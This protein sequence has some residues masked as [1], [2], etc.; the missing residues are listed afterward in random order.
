MSTADFFERRCWKNFD[1]PN[2]AT[3]DAVA[4]LRERG[5]TFFR[6]TTKPLVSEIIAEG[7]RVQPKDQGD[8]PL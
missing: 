6:I 8:P 4:S 7:W 5:A 3:E 2:A 1:S